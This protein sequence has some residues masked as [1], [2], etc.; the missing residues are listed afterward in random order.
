MEAWTLTALSDV[1]NVMRA[2][3]K[4]L[5]IV[6][7][8][9]ILSWFFAH[10]QHKFSSGFNLKFLKE[11]RVAHC[12]VQPSALDLTFDHIGGLDDIKNDLYY[13]VVLPMK[14]PDVFYSDKLALLRP[15][16]G[17]LFTGPPGTGKTI[18]AK[19]LAKECN[20]PLLAPG[21]STLENKYYGESSKMLASVFDT[22]RSLQP[23]IVFLDEIDGMMRKRSEEDQSCVYSMKTEFLAQMDGLNNRTD[24]K[25]V[26][27]GCTNAASSLDAALQRRM[28]KVYEFGVPDASQRRSILS[29][30]PEV[31]VS[32]EQ[33][34]RLVEACDG[35]TGNDLKEVASAACALRLKRC[36]QDDHFVHTLRSG[37]VESVR[38]ATSPISADEWSTSIAAIRRSMSACTSTSDGTSTRSPPSP[39]SVK[40]MLDVMK[41]L[42]DAAKATDAK[43]CRED[44][45]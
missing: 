32:E 42:R 27:I 30:I 38:K 41:T 5:V 22:A 8:T 28:R 12:V 11:S 26:I 16:K 19:A 7:I 1:R 40:Q 13:S 37:T 18:M 24:D 35:F 44:C 23:C 25:F 39:T 3:V 21:L 45:A 43:E 36:M 31:D 4:S 14:N 6:L 2:L 17:I 9:S 34:Q 33:M 20:V 29:V 10:V 15:A